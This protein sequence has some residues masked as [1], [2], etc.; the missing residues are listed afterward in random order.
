[1]K[2]AP[3]SI[4]PAAAGDVPY[5]AESLIAIARSVRDR[6]GSS[7]NPFLPDTVTPREFE[8]ALGFLNTGNKLALI[9]R[10]V[11][12]EDPNSGSEG[13]RIGCLLAEISPSSVPTLNAGQVGTVTACWVSPSHR[14]R[15]I[16]KALSD[17]AETWFREAGV[18]FAELSYGFDSETAG[19]AWAVLGYAP[20]RVFA[21][22]DLDL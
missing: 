3:V 18:R 14:R 1:M 5:I 7:Y 10:A 6:P 8:Y 13:P 2:E 19:A 17:R 16:G 9:A 12:N 22:K 15:G 11:G 20:F 21:V 4:L